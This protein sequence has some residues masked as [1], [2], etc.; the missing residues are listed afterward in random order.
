MPF[1]DKSTLTYP[2][3]NSFPVRKY[4]DTRDPVSG[5]GG[6]FKL[7]RL[8]DIWINESNQAA[9]IM[10][11]R[12]VDAGSWLRMGAS[13]TGILTL[14]GDVGGAVSEDGANNVNILSGSDLTV[15]GVPAANTL[16]I[17]LDGTVSS[18]FPTDSGTALPAGGILNI[19]GAGGTDTSGAGNTV[20]V[21]SGPT[22]PTSFV[23]D[24]GTATPAANILNILGGTSID[25]AGAGDT[26]T[27]NAG[28]DLANTYT[29]DSGSA[30]PSANNINVVGSGSTT[31]TGA[32]STVTI[33]SSGGGISW[34]EITVVGPTQLVVDMGYVTN[35]G[36][37]VGLLLPL[38]STF[39]SVIDVVGKGLGG[40]IISQNAGQT[41]HLVSSSTT[42]GVTGTVA[43]SAPD[44][45]GSTLSMVCI[46]ADT[47][48]RIRSSTGN[49][50]FT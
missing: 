40:F 30:T 23:T 42:V 3:T 28:S 4:L 27:I 50:I 15:T 18:S 48:W 34:N 12:S 11:D 6:D 20:T 41:I 21:S 7:F 25:T 17:T 9:F 45:F 14:T 13:G 46:T 10:V 16:T 49:L 39:G 43:T 26:V 37:P 8:F 24:A 44:E 32:G 33:S 2:A 31:T 22:V 36:S 19:F 1:V 35:S 47:E 29:C 38:T 5:L